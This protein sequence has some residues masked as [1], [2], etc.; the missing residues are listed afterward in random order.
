[1]AMFMKKIF[2]MIIKKNY[3]HVYGDFKNLDKIF[4]E[5]NFWDLFNKINE[6]DI[7][8]LERKES[9]TRTCTNLYFNKEE[10]VKLVSYGISE[11]RFLELYRDSEVYSLYLE[12][13]E[14]VTKIPSK[15]QQLKI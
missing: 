2:W 6:Y 5:K 12:F 13:K 8:K 3:I 11:L 10:L 15:I 7:N 1:M 14:E 9:S 4:R